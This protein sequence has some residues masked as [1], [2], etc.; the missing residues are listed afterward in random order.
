M[1]ITKH[2]VRMF[3]DKYFL[4]YYGFLFLTGSFMHRVLKHGIG[5]ECDA[6]GTAA[7]V[8][9]HLDGFNSILCYLSP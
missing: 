3:C 2:Y 9:F 7:Y 4:S 1:P 8:P 6:R 5:I